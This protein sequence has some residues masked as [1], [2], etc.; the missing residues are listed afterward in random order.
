MKPSFSPLLKC[1][2]GE[3]AMAI[4]TD[5]YFEQ[6][7]LREL[8]GLDFRRKSQR[9][10]TG[11]KTYLTVAASMAAGMVVG[12]FAVQSL[13]A[14]AKAPVF[15]V[16]EI[17]VTNPEAY[18]KEFAPKAQAT[19]RSSGG[20]FIVIGGAAGAGAKP[21]TAIEGTPPKRVAI[22]QWESFDAMNTWYKSEAYQEALKIGKQHATFRRYAVE[23]Q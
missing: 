11:M 6:I 16:S 2:S 21:I 23:G 1:E 14:Q 17:D 22:Q 9:E 19:I 5:A 20:K 12:G 8:C 4:Q 15:L 10:D 13:H 3:Q 18:G 7:S